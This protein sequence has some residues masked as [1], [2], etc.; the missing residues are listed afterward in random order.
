MIGGRILGLLGYAQ[1]RVTGR[2]PEKFIN[3]AS[4]TGLRMWDTAISEGELIFK[5]DIYSLKSLWAI[6]HKT[7]CTIELQRQAGLLVISRFLLKRKFLLAGFFCFCL[8]LFILA[9]TVWSIEVEGIEELTQEQI[10]DSVEPLGLSRW[11]RYRTLD[12]NEIEE[13]LYIQ[14][15]QIAWI[16]IDRSGTKITIR[17][18]EKDY[19]PLQF[20]KPIDIVAEYDGIISEM[21]V[22]QG[23]AMVEPG[24]TVAKGDV[25]ISGCTSDDGIVNAAGSVK[26]IIYIE[27]Y[28]EAALEEVERVAT[29]VEKEVS[30]L[31]VGS[32]S[33]ALSPREHGFV[34]FDV[35]ENIRLIR[36]KILPIKLI[37]LRYQELNLF[38]H[39]YTP[40]QAEELARERAMISAHSQ[41][42]EF[43]DVLKTEVK[44]ITLEN[45]IYRYKI[46]LT[47]ESN[48]GI[49]KVQ[50][51]G[52]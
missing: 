29:G 2:F 5:T 18:V 37:T 25:L 16:A 34:H 23:M 38:I 6:Q 13:K 28:G 3:L 31:H 22:L 1:I 19:D 30:F 27:G 44:D 8:T 7:G 17:V 46:L 52:E 24:M 41:V 4:A 14:Y 36:G 20:G 9:G 35:T 43:S 15:P 39:Y 42:G 48:I 51:K 33:I 21:M 50:T 11:V 32:V 45:N 40:E 47:I 26:A 10:M 12:L 49:E